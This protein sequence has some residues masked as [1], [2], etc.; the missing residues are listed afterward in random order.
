MVQA[1]TMQNFAITN[2]MF[3]FSN[4]NEISGDMNLPKQI[5]SILNEWLL[6]GIDNG[7]SALWQ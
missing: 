3:S 1:C 5:T 6:E 4:L 2:S 7:D